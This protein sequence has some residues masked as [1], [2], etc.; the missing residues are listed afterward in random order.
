MVETNVA[1]WNLC[2][3]KCRYLLSPSTWILQS[4]T[5]FPA[6]IFPYLLSLSYVSYYIFLFLSLPCADDAERVFKQRL[7]P[8]FPSVFYQII[9]TRQTWQIEGT[10]PI[11]RIMAEERSVS[12]P[13]SGS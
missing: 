9:I 13:V 4:Y 11:R 8:I 10:A 5:R 12:I 7:V 6:C 3:G 2:I 1:S